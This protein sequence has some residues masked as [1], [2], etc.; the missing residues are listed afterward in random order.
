MKTTQLLSILAFLVAATF[1]HAQIII[2]P[3]AVEGRWTIDKSPYTID[4]AIYVRPGSTLFIEP[5]VEVIFKTRDRMHIYGC[6]KARGT[7]KQPI[8]FTAADKAIGWGGIWFTQTCPRTDTSK[9]VYCHFQ[10]GNAKGD[11]PYNSGGAVGVRELDKLLIRHCTFEYN[12]ALYYSTKP[13]TGGAIALWKSD[14]RISHCIFRY[15]IAD[16]GGAISINDFSK[17]IIDNCLLYSN[18]VSSYGGAVEVYNHSNPSFVSCTF[19]DNRTV[20]SGGAFDICLSSSAYL[21]NCILWY[22]TAGMSGNQV[23]IR[24][25]ES[26]VKMFYCNLEGGMEGISGFPFIASFKEMLNAYPIFQHTADG[27]YS[28]SPYS[29]CVETGSIDCK[30]FPE[31]WCCPCN[32]LANSMRIGKQQIDMGCFE[33]HDTNPPDE[34]EE[35]LPK[36]FNV[37][38]FPS[39]VKNSATIEYEL[40]ETKAVKLTVYDLQ[41]KVVSDLP[42]VEQNVGTH[43]IDWNAQ[44]L[45]NGIY[46]YKLQTGNQYSSGQLIVTK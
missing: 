40:S 28:L 42:M 9:L 13:P 22:N 25:E 38:V 12:K 30:Y 43:Q 17:P 24:S 6:F 26:Y 16:F 21:L 7:E 29:P 19:A 8:L 14:I 41:G 3:G 23:N 31:G 39:P 36:L 44:F 46:I 15:N 18:N 33:Y 27:P 5:G 10:Y 2:P 37:V 45:P 1:T 11:S 35:A 32:D 20:Y 4:G 34:D